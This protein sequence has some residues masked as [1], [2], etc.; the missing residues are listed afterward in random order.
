VPV[1]T[2]TPCDPGKFIWLDV[3]GYTGVVSWDFST[4]GVVAL[5]PDQPAGV[6][7]EYY[8][9]IKQGESSPQWHKGP[10]KTAVPC[11][12]VK[13]GSVVIA[14]WGVADGRAKKIAELTVQVGPRPPPDVT[15]KPVE[16]DVKPVPVTSFRVIMVFESGA[17]MPQ[18]QFDAMFGGVVE[19]WMT[20]NCTGGK[21]TGW[22][23]R[24]KDADGDEDKSMAALW[25]AVKPK[26][27]SV[28]AVAVEVNGAVEIIPVE[29]T[30]AAM[31]A[32]LKTYKGVK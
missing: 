14:A 24:D 15:P 20:A 17:K 32:K 10:S 23:R 4:P 27:T 25:T 21:A 8:P 19:E 13:E 26:V 16:P 12:G 30:P 6:V 2:P 31:L 9:G 18:G 5:L 7:A 1:G 3:S 22:R 29:A 28:P 11:L